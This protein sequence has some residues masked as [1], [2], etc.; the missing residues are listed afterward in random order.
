[1]QLPTL[2]ITLKLLLSLVVHIPR[3]ARLLLHLQS[4][5][6]LLASIKD[7]LFPDP[8]SPNARKALGSG[9]SSKAA[10]V[11]VIDVTEAGELKQEKEK[12][13][14]AMVNLLEVLVWEAGE[15]EKDV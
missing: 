12:V 5:P 1:M 8:P 13:V 10:A 15:G 14:K 3:A 9:S 7:R 11:V 6:L 4:F 2:A